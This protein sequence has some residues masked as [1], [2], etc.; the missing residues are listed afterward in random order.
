MQDDLVSSGLCPPEFCASTPLPSKKPAIFSALSSGVI[1]SRSVFTN[2]TGFLVDVFLKP[3]DVSFLSC[4]GGEVGEDVEKY[5]L[6]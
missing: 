5:S 3:G 1:G 6:W 4:I 2:R